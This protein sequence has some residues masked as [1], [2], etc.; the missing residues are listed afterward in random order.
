[1]AILYLPRNYTPEKE[2][3]IAHTLGK[4]EQRHLLVNL[5]V[6]FKKKK[7]QTKVTEDLGGKN[8]QNLFCTKI[9]VCKATQNYQL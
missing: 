1:M 2:N 6:L 9:T 8:K 7:G 3:N 4:L 5:T